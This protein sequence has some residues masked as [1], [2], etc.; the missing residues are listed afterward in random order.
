[1]LIYLEL[2]VLLFDFVIV[3]DILFLF[4]SYCFCYSLYYVARSIIWSNDNCIAWDNIII[5]SSSISISISIC[6]S[7]CIV[8]I[9]IDTFGIIDIS[10]YPLLSTHYIFVIGL[11]LVLLIS[12][13]L[14][15]CIIFLQLFIQLSMNPL[16]PMKVKNEW[17]VHIS[18]NIVYIY[19]C[20]N[21]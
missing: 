2:Y 6:I 18:S 14:T 9:K 12:N 1:M 3:F 17:Y 15:V 10:K 11:K 7:V 19:I 8:T 20:L 5:I 4:S 16:L 21:W 13:Y